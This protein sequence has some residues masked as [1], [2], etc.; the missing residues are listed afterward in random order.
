MVS[1]LQLQMDH[2]K[3][4]NLEETLTMADENE[5]ERST[6]VAGVRRSSRNRNVEFLRRL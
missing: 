1:S 6:K 2:T 5:L 4:E 3:T